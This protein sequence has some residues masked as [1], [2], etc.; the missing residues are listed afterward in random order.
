MLDATP[1]ARGAGAASCDARRCTTILA[2][3][4][5]EAL[6]EGRSW[7]A[8]A[9]PRRDVYEISL[10]QLRDVL[11][12]RVRDWSQL[13]GAAGAIEAY[14]AAEDAPEIAT[15]L[16][17]EGKDLTASRRPASELIELVRAE[18][19]T[20]AI[21]RPEALTPDVLALVVQGHDPLGDP[22]AT[23]PLRVGDRVPAFDPV[24]VVSPGEILPVRCANAAL[25]AHGDYSVMF[26]S[27]RTLLE[28]ADIAIG[29]L[30]TPLTD[31]SPPTPCES[32]FTLQGSPRAAEAIAGAGIDLL[33]VN[34]NHMFD[35]WVP[36]PPY[37]ALRDT[38]AR[39]HR[40]GV[41]TVGAG[42]NLR[43]ARQ[44]VVLE[45]GSGTPTKFAFLAYDEIAPWNWA[46][47]GAPGTAPLKRE[48]VIEDVRAAR[49]VADV[50]IVG[51]S[52]GIEYTPDP[53]ANQRD[54][55]AAAVEAG[56]TLVV[57]N[58]PHVVE[59]I[60]RR[61]VE[62]RTAFVIYAQGN[63]IFDQSWSVPTTQAVL[64]EAGF[65]DGRLIGYRLRPVVTRGNAELRRG[66]YR[67][68]LVPPAGAEG[69]E[70]LGR[71]WA[72]QD[73]LPR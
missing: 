72:A 7:V 5:T 10:D 47:E 63:Y 27:V 19:P 67:P 14:V 16:G 38:L 54:L 60:E 17:V 52:W 35:C 36:C 2:P 37:A 20:L 30:D 31:V 66:L 13:G 23:S 4:A 12:G 40:L 43:E 55:A 68:E 57:G 41:R 51:M 44:P 9:H 50:V 29:G 25:E 65:V 1:P 6:P 22:S 62:G 3:P 61:T 70:I 59:A 71:I 58:H 21:V 48:T 33:F 8:I 26:E 34:G 18:P 11:A 39:L 46:T 42:E 45:A 24:L 32:T 73:R 64:L 56:A 15:V 49:A 69:R 53:T 28:R